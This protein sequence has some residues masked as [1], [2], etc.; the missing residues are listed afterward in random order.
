MEGGGRWLA[1]WLAGLL[2]C[3]LAGLAGLP[4]GHMGRAAWGMYPCSKS[5]P[6]SVTS[7]R[8]VAAQAALLLGSRKC[9]SPPGSAPT[10]PMHVLQ[11]RQAMMASLSEEMSY[12]AM[13]GYHGGQQ[14]HGGGGGGHDE[15]PSR[16]RDE[17]DDR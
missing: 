15:Q 10:P 7:K 9:P 12:G 1:G 13:G 11:A 17:D 8:A 16:F 14:Q 4:V 2:A 3:W 6:A 5:Q